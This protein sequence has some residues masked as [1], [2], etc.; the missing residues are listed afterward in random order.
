MLALA[1]NDLPT[2]SASGF[3]IR[4]VLPRS[5]PPQLLGPIDRKQLFS[6]LNI[7]D[8]IIGVGH[9]SPSEFTGHNQQ[10]LMDVTSIP[11]VDGKVI[12]L[13][14]CETAQ[15]LGPAL[16]N[17]GAL[18]YIGF[19][20]DLVWVCDADRASKPWNDELARPVMGP[21][22]ECVNTILDGKT[23]QEAYD[24]LITGLTENAEVEEDELTREC[25]L[26]NKMNAVL[27]GNPE[28][29][30]GSRP[31]IILPIGPPPLPPLF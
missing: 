12:I 27:L 29:R 31:R 2:R 10:I 11:N 20:K 1:L 16:I 5:G 8:V 28:G 23:I 17:A 14:S 22:I 25:I 24:T 18:S 7:G 6:T 26:F 21:I 4:Y 30:V 13:I 15:E 9:G 19:K 3:I